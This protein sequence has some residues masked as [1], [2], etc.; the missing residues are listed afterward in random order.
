M[1]LHEQVRTD[2]DELECDA[3]HRKIRFL[4]GGP[5]S[6]KT[7]CTMK[8]VQFL[9]H[10][11]LSVVYAT[12][13]GKLA[14]TCPAADRLLATTVHR[15]FGITLGDAA[16]WGSDTIFEYGAWIID[17]LSM[18]SQRHFDLIVHTWN[19]GGRRSLLIFV[20][21]FKQ[22]PPVTKG[23]AEIADAQTSRHWRGL[24]LAHD[25]GSAVSFR[26]TDSRLLHFQCLVRDQQPDDQQ[27]TQFVNDILLGEELSGACLERLWKELPRAVVLTATQAAGA[28]VNNWANSHFGRERL[29]HVDVWG[30][31]DTPPVPLLPFRGTTVALTSTLD[32]QAGLVNGLEGKVLGVSPAGVEL[33]L[34]TGEVTAIWRACRENVT[35]HKRHAYPIRLAYANT[36]HQFEGQS[37]EQTCICF[38]SFAP[39]GW[40]YTAVTRARSF[41]GLRAIGSPTASHFRP[42]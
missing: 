26:T 35:P 32:F 24:V 13:T 42:R 10:E 20:G 19:T 4:S 34:G 41:A 37:V 17:E 39:P 6:G 23:R 33:V 21:D 36:V 12:P 1:R 29:G 5:G 2:N 38:E 31:N 9:L 30:H 7:L 18:I 3:V 28:F 15:A 11:G 8:A 40:A 22:L 27:V 14:T 16:E 25:L